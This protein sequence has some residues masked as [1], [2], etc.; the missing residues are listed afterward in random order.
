MRRLRDAFGAIPDADAGVDHLGPDTAAAYVDGT[1][2][3]IDAEIVEG[4]L[5]ACDMCAEDVADLRATRRQLVTGTAVAA[6]PGSWTRWLAAGAAAAIVIL[7]VM[8]WP[9]RRP[10]PAPVAVSPPPQ[11]APALVL[12]DGSRDLRV[13]ADG[14]LSGADTLEPADRAALLAAIRTGEIDIPAEAA[15]LR[16]EPGTLLGPARATTFAVT[17]PVATAVIETTPA[18]RWQPHAAAQRY[19][20]STF[21]QQF[22]PV[23]TS[24][25]LTTTE[26]TPASPLPADR[27]LIWQVT[28]HTAEGDV[29]APA[30]PA[31]EA[32]FRVL[33]ADAARRLQTLAQAQEGSPITL[34]VLY[35]RAGVLDRAERAID[36]ALAAN[37]DAASLVVLRHR[38]AAAR[39]DLTTRR[40]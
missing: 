33:P 30:P 37:P 8:V 2:S 38:I 9:T 7:A 22:T 28:A 5:D 19:T 31:A 12:R 20:V 1:L 29:R 24:P 10:A 13:E 3:P 11:A 39:G 16:A 17:S 27:T 4:H 36:E 34:S 32:R 26:W 35:A 23:A 21:D 25:R 6:R 14:R 40:P 18:F 15:A